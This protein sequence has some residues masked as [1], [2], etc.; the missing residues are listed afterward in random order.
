MPH[1]GRKTERKMPVVKTSASA[2]E[3]KEK[4]NNAF[5]DI[6]FKWKWTN[7]F[8]VKWSSILVKGIPIVL[9]WEVLNCNQIYDEEIFGNELN[10][11][12]VSFHLKAFCSSLYEKLFRLWTKFSKNS[13]VELSETNCNRC[14]KEPYSSKLILFETL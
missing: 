10:K 7:S 8:R 9:K 11:V 1:D 14:F 6:L 3:L 5:D 2:F 13:F 4:I 12:F